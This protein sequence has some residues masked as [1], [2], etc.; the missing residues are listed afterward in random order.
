MLICAKRVGIL[1]AAVFG[2][3]LLTASASWADIVPVT[4]DIDPSTLHIGPGA[5]TGLVCSGGSNDVATGC[6]FDPNP[7][8][9]NRLDIYQESGGTVGNTVGPMLLILGIPN[10]S[11]AA[12][13]ISSVD[14]IS[15]YPGSSTSV[16]SFSL[17]GTNAYSG[18][19]NVSTGFVGSYLN[20]ASTPQ[21]YDF[22]GLQA[23]TDASEN[24]SNWFGLK[25]QAIFG[26][27]P[28]SFG[29]YVYRI[30]SALGPK[31]L[32]DITFSGDLSAGTLA[33]AYA[34]NGIIGKGQ[35]IFSTPFTE[36]GQAP[37]IPEPGTL[38]LFG[39]GLLGVAGLVRRLRRSGS[40]N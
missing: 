2:L 30:N 5:N 28:S 11:G 16:S 37:G 21:V 35:K 18:V 4:D 25:E 34:Q 7:I 12:P 22:I 24:V 17:G 32:F 33:I 6:G 23:P 26:S 3:C 10:F 20:S 14:K 36:A 8:S 15:P 38:A 39:T 13:A 19:W 29:I 9:T 27:T 31:G 1:I 40:N